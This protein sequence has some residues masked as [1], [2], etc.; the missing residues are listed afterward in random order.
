MFSVRTNEVQKFRK[1][2][3]YYIFWLVHVEVR[4]RVT[5]TKRSPVY[6][7]LQT[8]LKYHIDYCGKF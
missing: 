4:D 1:V 2:I 3:C 6:F 8:V 7:K 5:R